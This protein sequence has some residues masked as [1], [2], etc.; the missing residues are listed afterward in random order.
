ME[1]TR[2][3]TP[4]FFQ[5]AL[6]NEIKKITGDMLFH[7]P[8]G[9][10]MVKLEVF[11]QSLPIPVLES[12]KESGD[13]SN[14]EYQGSQIDEPIFKCPWCSVKIAGG[15]VPGINEQQAIQVV[16]CF[17]IFND[18]VSNQG[19]RELLNLFQRIYSRFA[20]DPILDGQYTCTGEFEWALQDEDTYP[21]FFGALSTSFKFMGYRREN[22]FL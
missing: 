21:H 18:D 9:E 15:N 7:S 6:A 10:E 5:E 2:A 4:L 13:F 3:R 8:K 22:K 19:H 12:T 16:V 1:S 11:E 20:T 17:G 14:L